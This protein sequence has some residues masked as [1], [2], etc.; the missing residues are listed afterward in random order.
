MTL[1]P[2]FS[3]NSA[4]VRNRALIHGLCLNGNYVDVL[5]ISNNKYQ[6]YNSVEKENKV[7]LY[8]AGENKLYNQISH[9]NKSKVS[10]FGYFSEKIIRK[11]VH[12]IYPWDYTMHIARH[13]SI[14]KIPNKHYDMVVSSSNPYSSHVA[15]SRLI[16]QGLSFGRWVQYWGDPLSNDVSKTNW[17]PEIILRKIEAKLFKGAYKIVFVSPLTLEY[18]AKTHKSI[19]DK[20]TWLPIPYKE[21]MLT[22]PSSECISYFGDY[23]KKNRDIYPLYRSLKC[24]GKQAIIAGDGDINLQ[25]TNN[26]QILNRCDINQYLINT[27]ILV[28]ILNKYGT[29]IPGKLYHCARADVPVLVICERENSMR[30][31]SYFKKYDKYHFCDNNVECILEAIKRINNNYKRSAPIAEFRADKIAL[32]LSLL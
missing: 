20:M 29:Q 7:N 23:Y 11:I 19:K 22:S 13:I 27:R 10:W 6:I 31:R 12:K 5:T 18:E 4:M 21:K 14:S 1:Y 9:Q 2:Y 16:K 28:V 26:L 8:Y 25:A 3:N 32:E 15:V 24:Y 17:I 30:L